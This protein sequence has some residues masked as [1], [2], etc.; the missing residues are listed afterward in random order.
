MWDSFRAVFYKEWLH[1]RRDRMTLMMTLM[2]PMIQMMVYGWLDTNVRHIPTVYCDESRS[3]ES[4]R[5]I[6]ELRATGTF[7]LEPVNTPGQARTAVISSRARVA[8]EIPPDFHDRMLRQENAQVL[9]LVDGSEST[10]ASTAVGAAGGVAL[11]ESVRRLAAHSG[12]GGGGQIEARPVVLFNPDSRTANYMI[13]GLV[14]VLL[15]MITSVLT[16]ISIVR[17]RERGTLEQLL[18]TPVETAGLMLGKVAPYMAVGFGELT[19]ILLVMHFVFEVPIHGNLVFLYVMAL[20]YVFALLSIGLYVS[21][22]AQTQQQAQGTI[23]MFFLPSMF[24]SGYIFPLASLPWPLRIL[25][26]CFPVTHF[27]EIMRGVVLR[28]AGPMELWRSCLALVI[29]SVLLIV[30]SVWRFQKIS[31]V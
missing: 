18:V 15:Q 28:G 3:T 4:R 1:I 8:I 12:G 22:G 21:I 2:I 14:A 7:D 5:F 19:G 23:Q 16:A 29:I 11:S 6:D 13:P 26:Q 30:A 24:L 27:I 17:E 20:V 10:V 31:L 25:G 9:V